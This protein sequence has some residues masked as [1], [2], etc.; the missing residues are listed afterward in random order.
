M[1]YL[2]VKLEESKRKV[3]ESKGCLFFWILNKLFSH[4][5]NEENKVTYW[6]LEFEYND[7]NYKN[8]VKREIGLNENG[9][10]IVRLPNKKNELGF[11]ADEDVDYLYF[12]NHFKH[13]KISREYFEEKWNELK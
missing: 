6:L 3:I 5:F 8:E 2:K 11:W 4:K 9:R 12:I 10:I 1:K 13:V 7:W